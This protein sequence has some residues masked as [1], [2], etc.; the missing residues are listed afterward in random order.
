MDGAG[1]STE[2]DDLLAELD[3]VSGPPPPPAAPPPAVPATASPPVAPAAV[4]SHRP[5]ESQPSP[6]GASKP[7]P[8][9]SMGFFGTSPAST[10]PAAPPS[11]AP[12]AAPPGGPSPP[13]AQPPLGRFGATEPV[14]VTRRGKGTGLGGLAIFLGVVCLGIAIV[15]PQFWFLIG[16]TFAGAAFLGGMTFRHAIN[17]D[18]PGRT[19]GGIAVV[20]AV[21]AI[22][23]FVI[24]LQREANR[25]TETTGGGLF[26]AMSGIE[27]ESEVRT[28][29]LDGTGTAT[30]SLDGQVLEV[31]LEACDFSDPA[32][33]VDQ[34]ARGAA[35]D[36][37]RDLTVTLLSSTIGE[38][39]DAV[40][41]GLGA[42]GY[43]LTGRNLFTVEGGTLT[44]AG[45]MREAFGPGRVQIS[46]TATCSA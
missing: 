22:I 1:G 39:E 7:Q 17:Y 45:E 2:F 10:P 33:G 43:V 40:S 3:S 12:A 30:V 21:L 36:A 31:P 23:T 5:T 35:T 34:A 8:P 6:A 11:A 26:S 44:V 13:G 19:T 42:N 28:L 15:I 4:A 38:T 46:L 41:V 37:G 20:L 25:A 16:L 14:K 18:T 27:I 32:V 9:D 24:G 29:L